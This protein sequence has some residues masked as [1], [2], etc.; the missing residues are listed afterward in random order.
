M[1]K[2][3]ILI[4][5]GNTP[6][7]WCWFSTTSS[8][9]YGLPEYSF[10]FMQHQKF[11]KQLKAKGPSSFEYDLIFFRGYSN[12][13]LNGDNIISFNIPFISSLATGGANL[14]MRLNEMESTAKKAR[15]IMVQNEYAK[16][17][18][19]LAGYK[20]VHLI[21][22]GV[23]TEIFKPSKTIDENNLNI[24]CAG[25]VRGVRGALKGV[26][27]IKSA[28]EDTGHKYQEVNLDNRKTHEEMPNW[29]R[30]LKYYMQPSEAEEASNSV[31]EAM[32]CGIPCFIC[33]NVGYHG[34][35]CRCGTEYEDGQ[36][37]FVDRSA[38]DIARKILILE[39]N[40]YIAN[41]IRRNARQFSLSHKWKHI[42]PLF[43]EM[44]KSAFDNKA[45]QP[46]SSG[47]QMMLTTQE[48]MEYQSL[49]KEKLQLKE[50]TNDK[51]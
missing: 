21:P 22:N 38:G 5:V 46:S 45:I 9:A 20:N 32:S 31:T 17:E 2:K 29:Y 6:G 43:R 44:F 4:V 39:G 27:F 47:I 41:R 19:R 30:S 33:R 42:V 48:Y 23:N 18:A 1:T 40:P 51:D 8:M 26:N 13:Y 10:A 3:K 16:Y 37:V 14:P 15:A 28:C 36:V 35:V 34:E 11:I 12:L 7:G 50:I 24:G 49:K 25:N